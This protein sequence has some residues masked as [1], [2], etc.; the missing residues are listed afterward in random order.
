MAIKRNKNISLS[1]IIDG[2]LCSVM[3]KINIPHLVIR[4]SFKNP[5]ALNGHSDDN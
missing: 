2:D 5:L 4:T 3:M 1:F